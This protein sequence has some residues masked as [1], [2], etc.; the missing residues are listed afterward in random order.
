MRSIFRRTVSRLVSV[1]CWLLL[2]GIVYAVFV[3]SETSGAF[4]YGN[5]WIHYSVY[6]GAI[7]PKTVGHVV[8]AEAVPEEYLYARSNGPFMA[9]FPPDI[10]SPPLKKGE[11]FWIDEQHKVASLGRMLCADDIEDLRMHRWREG[12]IISSPEELQTA[13]SKEN[14]RSTG[15]AEL[16]V[17]TNH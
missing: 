17:A 5:L 12:V 14:I 6:S 15:R 2:V 8:V 9:V 16:S 10:V 13:I 7:W 4:R 1:A 3:P 11:T